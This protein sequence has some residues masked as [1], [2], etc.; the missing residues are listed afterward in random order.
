MFI[1]FLLIIVLSVLVFASPSFTEQIE[2]DLVEQMPNIPSPYEMRDWKLVTLGYDSLVFD[3]DL[4]GDYLPLIWW[5]QN[6]VNYPE[7]DSF[8]L[9]T[10]VGTPRIHSGEAINV[11]PAVISATLVGVDKS[12]QNGENW[13]LM[14]EEFF[15]NRPEENVY[16]NGPV[17]Q[18]GNDWWYDTMPNV[19]FY[20]LYD[21][22]RG[23]GDFDYQF[24][25]V[26]DQWLRA[27]EVMGGETTPW[28]FPNMNHRAFSLSTMTPLDEGV[29]EPEA[30]G[31]LGWILYNAYI[32]TGEEQY[33]I[34]AEWCLEFLDSRNTN[35]SYELQ[36][37][38][39]VYAAARMNAE[40]GTMYDVEQ[41]VNWCFEVTP[42]RNWGAI[43]GTWGDYDV[44]G[45]I[46]EVSFNSYAFMMNG[47]ETAGALVPMARYDDR[48]TRAIG[49]WVLNLANASRL[50]YPNYLPPENQDSE[51]WAYEYDPNSYI[52]H[53]AMREEFGGQSPFATGDAING[54]WGYTNLVLYGSSH[55]G[56]LGGII[57]TTNVSK[58]LQL[59]MLKTDYFQNNA[60]PT[61]LYFNPYENEQIVEIDLG[62]DTY[63][64]YDAVS[65]D[66]FSYGESGITEITIPGDEAIQVV[67]APAGGV[68][69]YYLDQM[70]IDDVVVDYNSGQQ[71]DNYPP[72]IKSL[73]A[74]P[75]PVFMEDETTVYCSAEDR[76]FDN[77]TYNW[78]ADDGD[79]QGNGSEVTFI[80][81][82][83]AVEVMITCVV[84]DGNE[85]SDTSV[86]VIDVL[87]NRPPDISSITADPEILNTGDTSTLTCIAT[88]LDGDSLLYAWSSVEGEIIGEGFVVEWTAPMS[89]G[90]HYVSCTVSDE[91]TQDIDSVGI[92]VGS[93]VGYYSFH[94]NGFDQSGFDN[95]GEVIEAVPTEDRFGNPNTAF[96]FDGEND[97][98]RIPVNQSLNFQ[99]EISLNFWMN[100]AQHPDGESFPI[101]HGSWENRWKVSIIPNHHLRWTLN[102]DNGIIDLDSDTIIEEDTWYNITVTFGNGQAKIYLDAE[103]DA[104][105]DHTGVINQ[106]NI[107]LTIGQILPGNTQYNFNGI[108][109]DVMIY[110]RVLSDEEIIE[111]YNR[112]A[113]ENLAGDKILP[114]EFVLHQNYPNPFNSSTT[115]TYSLPVQADVNIEVFNISGRLVNTLLHTK[116]SAGTYITRWDAGESS[117]G[118]YFIRMDAGS[119]HYVRKVV[120]I[121]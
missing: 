36:M 90:F 15:N 20:Q 44:S 108:I 25:S 39:G 26:A 8:G 121:K 95:H 4:V 32:E 112:T 42:L 98:I 72:R 56:I 119:Y 107:D 53:E 87:D 52:G 51:A 49:K 69:T 88:D 101:S 76:D 120:L 19:F 54:G 24:T 2:I 83:Y 109:D 14:C 71:V 94:G 28:D 12:D 105:R 70:K 33:R 66:L 117:S 97:H 115:I 96:Y 48:F 78:S 100:V 75:N 61:Y 46:G 38:Y 102:T 43:V 86:V 60:Y 106:S 9:E 74:D 18:S 13:V 116:K 110:N 23:T 84:E 118:I 6:P 114:S 99:E 10:V 7:H 92:V 5:N 55:V 58:I 79:I 103:P 31:A 30:A 45:L 63:D 91:G 62:D 65:N 93:R 3:F 35:P 11:L 29:R 17:S 50:F 111:L 80:P 34:G 57:D 68:V 81:P 113:V 59:D 21:N 85:S 73:A 16:L 89:Y 27:A 104:S 64:L 1:R 40:L 67:L 77:L 82:L 41:M 37:P 47:Y 22:Y